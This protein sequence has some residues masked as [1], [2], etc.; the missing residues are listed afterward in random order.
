MKGAVKNLLFLTAYHV[1]RSIMLRMEEKMRKEDN[2]NDRKTQAAILG[3]L[4]T[5]LGILY[6]D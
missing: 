1:T 6:N 3:S 2:I 4:Y 5:A